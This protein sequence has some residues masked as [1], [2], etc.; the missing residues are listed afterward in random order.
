MSSQWTDTMSQDTGYTNDL[1]NSGYRNG[2]IE[3]IKSDI[4]RKWEQPLKQ[5]GF[6]YVDRFR[7]TT[8]VSN[9]ID[10]LYHYTTIASFIDNTPHDRLNRER[11]LVNYIKE[12]FTYST[13]N[14]IIIPTFS[15]VSDVLANKSL[16]YK[17]PANRQIDDDT[18]NVHF[19]ALIRDSDI[20]A[21]IQ[22]AYLSLKAYGVIAVRPVIRLIDDEYSL[23]YEVYTPD[24]FRVL[25][26]DNGVPCKMLYESE[27]YSIEGREDIIVVWTSTEHY[28]LNVKGEK[29]FFSGN[30]NGINPYGR[31]PF[32]WFR[33]DESTFY[34][35]G[36]AE[37]VEANLEYNYYKLATQF[38]A[39]YSAINLF[40][41]TNLQSAFEGKK[42]LRPGDIINV[43]VENQDIQ[44]KGEFISPQVF[45]DKLSEQARQIY[46]DIS[47]R[48]GVPAYMFIE[49]AIE[50]SGKAVRNSMRMLLDEK[51]ADAIKLREAERKLAVLTCLIANYHGSIGQLKES[52]TFD[53]SK[54]KE[55]FY[56]DY[57]DEEFSDDPK[58]EY[59]LD[60]KR[61]NDGVKSIIQIIQ[62]HNPDIKS[63]DDALRFLR[64]NRQL[65]DE[66]SKQGFASLF[67]G[68]TLTTPEPV[69]SLGEALS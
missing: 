42:Y 60:M 24:K 54:I 61:V 33:S 9:E 5:E 1:D 13:L 41:G 44:V 51:S 10:N 36:C 46:K 68:T 28:Y 62:K 35:G 2:S 67:Q 30:E 6:G 22:S 32:S 4:R 55:K 26:D 18:Q 65:L 31:L 16:L 52:S 27:L 58:S 43:P 66:F 50:L 29:Y 8:D 57:S 34:A 17:R 69:S 47:I 15:F 56:I 45:F 12:Y 7:S 11:I 20:D 23:Q 21:K 40:L 39:N 64:E 25:L 3:S 53:I 14:R 63:K 19:Q 38:D 49:G 48:Y 59:D 37:L